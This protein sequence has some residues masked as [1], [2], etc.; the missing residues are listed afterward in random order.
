MREGMS[1]SF[2]HSPPLTQDLALAN[3]ELALAKQ[4]YLNRLLQ[5]RKDKYQAIYQIAQINTVVR[6]AR[7][8]V[9]NWGRGGLSGYKREGYKRKKQ[10]SN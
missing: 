9:S 1:A 4:R 7:R 5:T 8:V 6:L 10:L 2:V 3:Q